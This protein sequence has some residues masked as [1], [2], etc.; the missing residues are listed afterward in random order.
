M[1]EPL[2]AQF[3]RQTSA[4]LS[5]LEPHLL[6][7]EVAGEEAESELVGRIFRIVH[8]IRGSA[9]LL[10]L[11]NL[12]DLAR[13]IECVLDLL[14][15]GTLPLTQG[16]IRDVLRSCSV[17]Q[18]MVEG[19]AD[20][21]YDACMA[22]LKEHAAGVMEDAA[23]LNVRYPISLPDGRPIMQ[24]TGHE[25][26]ACMMNDAFLY[27]L[28]FDMKRDVTDK[29]ITPL[30]LLEYLQKSGHVLGT[31]CSGSLDDAACGC[32]EGH[33]TLFVLFSSILEPDLVD[34]VFMLDRQQIHQLDLTDIVN[35]GG[36]WDDLTE[37]YPAGETSPQ[38]SDTPLEGIDELMEEFDLAMR[39]LQE[40][41]HV[42]FEPWDEYVQEHPAPV[43][44]RQEGDVFDDLA[45]V[46]EI[47]EGFDPE[48]AMPE[49][50]LLVGEDSATEEAGEAP[51]ASMRDALPEV[52]EETVTVPEEVV[53][54][55]GPDEQ[56]LASIADGA[57]DAVPASSDAVADPD[58]LFEDGDAVAEEDDELAALEREFERA[59][60][61]EARA[62]GMIVPGEE[63]GPEVADS[64]PDAFQGTGADDDPDADLFVD[65]GREADMS[66]LDAPRKDAPEESG[67]LLNLEG[68]VGTVHGFSV[69]TQETDVVVTLDGDMTI[70][71]AARAREALLELMQEHSRV[72]IDLQQVE[73]AD[74]TFVQVLL[75]ARKSA[76][77]RGVVLQVRQP[78]AD[79]VGR[80]FRLCGLDLEAR[81]RLGLGALFA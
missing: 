75:A 20:E 1:P 24:M 31:H 26:E 63:D 71:N 35:G 6:E 61:A 8:A 27:V 38:V 70:A 50:A 29:D 12:E 60:V 74:V 69:V 41:S 47:L 78:V 72:D 9:S 42:P 49:G 56:T 11:E 17:V 19:E 33:T 65:S 58:A 43:A 21:H 14:R 81:K 32:A 64:A 22:T 73:S 52:L 18:T 66:Y 77:E 10:G 37:E 5:E 51:D 25:L 46:D 62:S 16:V 7:L 68:E 30:S 57:P 36:S 40:D 55:D 23:M 2:Q 44:A 53:M 80:V 39:K 76:D 67:V 28:E 4:L 13:L 15:S 45:P 54:P 34:A 59:L 48:E 79:A 3:F